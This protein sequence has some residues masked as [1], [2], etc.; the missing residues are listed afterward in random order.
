MSLPF[1]DG[2]QLFG[3]FD[4]PLQFKRGNNYGEKTKESSHQTDPIENAGK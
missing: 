1:I 4:S 2:L 3:I